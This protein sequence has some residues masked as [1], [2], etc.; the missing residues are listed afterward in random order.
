MHTTIQPLLSH[1]EYISKFNTN[2]ELNKQKY[3]KQSFTM[4]EYALILF[5]DAVVD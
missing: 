4:K 1:S 3:N 5:P 2:L